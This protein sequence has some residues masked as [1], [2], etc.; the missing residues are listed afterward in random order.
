MTNIEGQW[1]GLGLKSKLKADVYKPGD[2]NNPLTETNLTG[3][4]TAPRVAAEA[5]A[6]VVRITGG[7]GFAHWEQAPTQLRRVEDVQVE[8]AG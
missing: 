7:P 8:A 2:L 1:I 4:Y 6:A 3:R 5:L